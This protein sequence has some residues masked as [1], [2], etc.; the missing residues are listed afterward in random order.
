M[1]EMTVPSSQF[2]LISTLKAMLLYNTKP[3]VLAI[4]L[5]IRDVGKVLRARHKEAN[6]VLAPL[7]RKWPTMGKFGNVVGL[8]EP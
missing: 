2:P 3:L 8:F 5:Q 1:G 4:F 6:H 7:T